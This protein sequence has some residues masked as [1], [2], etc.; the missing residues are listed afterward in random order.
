MIRYE[1]RDKVTGRPLWAGQSISQ[2]EKALA[3]NGLRWITDEGVEVFAL[4]L[5][6]K[7]VSLSQLLQLRALGE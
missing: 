1:L 7:E 6:G 2:C 5:H 3:D 4:Y